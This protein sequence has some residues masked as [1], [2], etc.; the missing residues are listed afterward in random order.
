MLAALKNMDFQTLIMAAA[1]ADFRPAE[2]VGG[3]IKKAGGLPTLALAPAPDILKSLPR[4]KGQVFIGFAAED[5][6]IVE[7]A[8]G[9]LKDKNLDLVAANQAG[10]PASA[11]AAEDNH[12]WLVFKD[13]RAEEISP[14]PKFAAAW[15]I[16]DAASP[17]MG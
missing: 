17:L 9:K 14:R 2:R 5:R 6:D 4:A 7:R 15:A 1:P 11:F 13:G 10:G 8:R 3:K 12:L 16:I